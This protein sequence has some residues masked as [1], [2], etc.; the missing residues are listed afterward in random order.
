MPKGKIRGIKEPDQERPK[1]EGRQLITLPPGSLATKDTPLWLRSAKAIAM[2]EESDRYAVAARDRERDLCMNII[3]LDEDDGFPK[4]L[5][6]ILETAGFERF[7]FGKPCPN[8][9]LKSSPYCRSC[10]KELGE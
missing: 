3:P 9:S 10:K 2:I 5:A 6:L 1:P 8:N 4:R 7:A